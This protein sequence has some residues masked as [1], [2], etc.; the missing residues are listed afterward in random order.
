MKWAILGAAGIFGALLVLTALLYYFTSVSHALLFWA[1]LS[2]LA[3]SEP[4]L[5][6]F[7]TSLS[8]KAVSR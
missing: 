2:S 5:V 6:T 4:W 1:A 7:S 8:P 3:R